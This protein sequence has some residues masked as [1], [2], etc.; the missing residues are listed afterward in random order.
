[1]QQLQRPAPPRDPTPAQA[2]RCT[3]LLAS[4]A[5]PDFYWFMVSSL[6]FVVNKK[7]LTT[8]YKPL[9]TNQKGRYPA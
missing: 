7:I 1:M 3:S 9:T 4:C 2:R 5:T 8:N 6:W